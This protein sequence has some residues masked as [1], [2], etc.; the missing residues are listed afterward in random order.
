MK[1]L[2]ED[3]DDIRQL[4]NKESLMKPSSDFTFRVMQQI[5]EDKNFYPILYK[6]LLSRRAWVMIAASALFIV[7]ICL[8]I[9]A[10]NA[11]DTTVFSELLHKAYLMRKQLDQSFNFTSNTVQIVT[12]AM[13][14]MSILLTLDLWFSQ[15][16]KKTA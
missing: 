6:P 7:Y 4:L 15:K 9:V 1:E 10:G 11:T 2:F 16:T 13:M 8:E 14:S 5:E 12:L 3:N